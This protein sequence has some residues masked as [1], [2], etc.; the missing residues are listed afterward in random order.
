[1][2]RIARA[3]APRSARALTPRLRQIPI[4]LVQGL[5]AVEVLDKNKVLH[6]ILHT[7]VLDSIITAILPSAARP[8]HAPPAPPL[9][10][11]ALGQRR[12]WTSPN[13]RTHRGCTCGAFLGPAV[14]LRLRMSLPR[15]RGAA[16]SPPGMGRA[17]DRRVRRRA[18]LV[19]RIFLAL[20]PW[21][22][23]IMG[24]V[25]GLFS[26]SMLDFSVVTKYY[27]FQARPA[28]ATHAVRAARRRVLPAAARARRVRPSAGPAQGRALASA[29][30]SLG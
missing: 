7:P 18:G 22:L 27:V 28:R 17:R 4:G 14:S 6:F 3:H 21:L 25:Q 13:L 10:P 20:L 11:L 30:A 2:A 15:L 12:C 9:P 19:L 16:S 23:A 8:A 26:Q 5:L 29:R 1:V 24:R